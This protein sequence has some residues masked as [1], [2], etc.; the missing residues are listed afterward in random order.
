MQLLVTHSHIRLKSWYDG[1]LHNTGNQKTKDGHISILQLI[2]L[3]Y[4][5]T[6]LLAMKKLCVCRNMTNLYILS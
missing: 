5:Q 2:G 6:N 4:N 1:K 3:D